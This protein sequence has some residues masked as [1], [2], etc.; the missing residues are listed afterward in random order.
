MKEIK[1]TPFEMKIE[2]EIEEGSYTHVE[3]SQEWGKILEKA[4]DMKLKEKNNEIKIRFTSA[5]KKKFAL[6]LLKKH[7][8]D[9]FE[10]IQL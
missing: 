2:K 1:L 6:S 10:I 4:A 3:N 8:P 5:E 7:M 9:E